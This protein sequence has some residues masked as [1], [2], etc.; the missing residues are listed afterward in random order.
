LRFVSPRTGR[1]VSTAGAGEWRDRLLPLPAF[2]LGQGPAGPAEWLAGLRLT[3]HFL[4]RDV[5]GT[6]HRGV[7]AAREALVE[8]I[9]A[10]AAEGG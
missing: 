4:A 6:Q 2:L 7:P 8:R 5:F 9:G 3:G 1:A 10:L